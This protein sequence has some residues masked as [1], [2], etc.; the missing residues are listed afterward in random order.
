TIA[1]QDM[2]RTWDNVKRYGAESVRDR[3]GEG[4]G[5]PTGIPVG[6][7]FVLTPSADVSLTFD[8]N[9]YATARDRRSDFI[10]EATPEVRLRSRLPR[11]VLDFAMGA[12]ITQYA[13]EQ[14]LDSVGG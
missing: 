8:D 14:E 13:R 10:L 1:R 9:V 3:G 11:H 6:A 7:N 12:R 5:G 4:A 2:L